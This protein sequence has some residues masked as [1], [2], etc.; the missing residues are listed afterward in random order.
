[1]LK[2]GGGKAAAAEPLLHEESGRAERKKKLKAA[3]PHARFDFKKLKAAEPHM[4]LKKQSL[5]R[6]AAERS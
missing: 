3:E 2:L 6:S 5:K 1:V 4:K